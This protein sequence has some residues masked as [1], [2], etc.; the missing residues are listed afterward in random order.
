M[1]V[2][3]A[4]CILGS[5]SIYWCEGVPMYINEARLLTADLRLQ[6]EFYAGSLGLEVLAGDSDAVALGAGRSKLSLGQAP[7][8]WSGI[9]HFAFN[10]PEDRFAEAKG[11]LLQR[12]PL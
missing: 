2:E 5:E 10:I 11:W 9:Y 3:L 4:P 12:V 6:R 7:T 8:G 1:A